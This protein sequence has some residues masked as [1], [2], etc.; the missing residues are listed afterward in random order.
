MRELFKHNMRKGK[1]KSAQADTFSTLHI[2]YTS[3]CL[4]CQ[5]F[6]LALQ[7][8]HVLFVFAPCYPGR[9]SRNPSFIS[10]QTLLTSLNKER[11][12]SMPTS[13]STSAP[14][15]VHS[16]QM[17][18]SWKLLLSSLHCATLRFLQFHHCILLLCALTTL[19]KKL[20]AWAVPEFK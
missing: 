14:L 7:S 9:G 1:I 3:T 5:V 2:L 4:S 12:H 19:P 13:V 15:P 8:S 11:I 6:M 16:M 20:H 18:S 17:L 10:F